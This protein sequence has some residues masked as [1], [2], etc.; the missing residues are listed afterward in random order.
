MTTTVGEPSSLLTSI[1]LQPHTESFSLKYFDNP[2]T[3][4]IR[5]VFHFPNLHGPGLC[6]NSIHVESWQKENATWRE[7]VWDVGSLVR[8]FAISAASNPPGILAKRRRI[9]RDQN[10]GQSCRRHLRQRSPSPPPSYIRPQLFTIIRQFVI[11]FKDCAKAKDETAKHKTPKKSKFLL[12]ALQES[13]S[14]KHLFEWVSYIQHKTF[15]WRDI[16]VQDD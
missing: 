9:P 11:K 10:H 12:A 3:A 16:W 13:E 7:K 1:N 15:R 6:G 2:S 5:A 14:N 8:A 4:R